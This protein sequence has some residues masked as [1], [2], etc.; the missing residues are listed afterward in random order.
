M[1]RGAPPLQQGRIGSARF[2]IE[3]V[4]PQRR[5]ARRVAQ[6]GCANDGAPRKKAMKALVAL[7]ALFVA[8]PAQAAA[9]F[10]VVVGNNT[11]ATGRAKLW[12]AERDAERFAGALHEL[13]DFGSDRITLLRG[14]HAS[15]VKAAIAK[16]DERIAKAR[17]AGE[18]SLLVVYFSGHAGSGGL[19]LGD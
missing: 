4:D 18:R 14:A 2:G 17:T 16:A 3:G 7:A 15:D 19:E 10:A 11:G 6:G 8:L 5:A 12:F 13:G 1:L 9:R